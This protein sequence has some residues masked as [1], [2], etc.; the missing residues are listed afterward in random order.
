MQGGL[1]EPRG[2]IFRVGIN[3]GEVMVEGDDAYGGG[4]NIAARLQERAEP[5]SSPVKNPETF[6]LRTFAGILKHSF[7]P[8]WIVEWAANLQIEWAF[9]A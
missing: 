9:E 4:V 2:M 8:V 5:E 6:G 3:L 7:L 1:P